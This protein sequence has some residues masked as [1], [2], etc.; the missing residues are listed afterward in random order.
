MMNKQIQNTIE[1]KL[2]SILENG[3]YQHKQSLSAIDSLK[4]EIQ[5]TNESVTKSVEAQKSK[6]EELEKK[7]INPKRSVLWEFLYPISLSV[8]AAIIFWF[9][10]SYFPEHSRKKRIRVKLDLEIYQVYTEIFSL[11]DTVFRKNNHSPS[12]YQSQIRGEKLNRRDIEIGLQNKCLNETYFY[13]PEIQHALLPIG[14]SLYNNI[15]KID[16]IIDRL[17]NFGMYLHSEEILLFE[18]IRNKLNTYDLENYERN[19]ISVIGGMQ[20]KPVN[21][22][23]SYMTNNFNEL[24]DLYKQLQKLVFQNK[25]E[26]RNIFVSKVQYHFY[27]GQYE[28][29]IKLIK[30]NSHKYSKDENFLNWYIFQSLYNLKRLPESYKLIESLFE[31]KA[32][33]VSSRNSLKEYLNDKTIQELLNKYYSE[34]DL[35]ELNKVIK[36]EELIEKAFIDN[37]KSLEDF[38]AK[39]IA[40]N[41]KK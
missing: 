40:E 18:N 10:F 14:K 15:Q 28:E 13:Y 17:F 37:A 25:L 35:S 23:L 11:F 1:L 27:N 21:P 26:N 12:D 16:R 22:S 38:Y 33:L 2:D 36:K 7:I 6:L 5:K 41:G 39:K 31:K 32:H 24:Y 3:K 20:L 19:A 29:T 34:K 9:A 8:I 4:A 30:N